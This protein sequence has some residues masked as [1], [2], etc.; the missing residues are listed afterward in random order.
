MEHR[1][2]ALAPSHISEMYRLYEDDFYIYK[3]NWLNRRKCELRDVMSA[4][5][6]MCACVHVCA[7]C[8]ANDLCKGII[9]TEML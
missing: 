6:G 7:L 2:V 9:S 5:V 4:C 3:E 8:R 1:I